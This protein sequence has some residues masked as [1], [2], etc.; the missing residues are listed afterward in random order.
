M[1]RRASSDT[2]TKS[3]CSSSVVPMP[4]AAPPGLDVAEQQV[5]AELHAQAGEDGGEE[6]ADDV[7]VTDHQA[8]RSEGPHKAD[9][10]RNA[11][12]HKRAR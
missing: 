8:R 1:A 3:Q 5:D 12:H 10:E 9:E 11:K 6:A 4:I 7:E 2:N